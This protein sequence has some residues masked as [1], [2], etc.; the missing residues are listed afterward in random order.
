MFSR[1]VCAGTLALSLVCVAACSTSTPTAD[2]PAVGDGDA[3]SEEGPVSGAASADA[4]AE[5]GAVGDLQQ[6]MDPPP[7]V[8]ARPASPVF[9]DAEY[10]VRVTEGVR[11]GQALSHAGWQQGDAEPMDLTLDVYEPAG[12]EAEAKPAVVMIHGGGFTGGSSAHGPL[13]L[14]ARYFAERGWV[15]FSINYRLA[16]DYGT[17]PASYPSPQTLGVTGQQADQWYALYPACRDGK[18]AIRWIRAH[19]DTYGLHPEY[20]TAVGGS[21]G[22][23]IALALGVSNEEDCRDEISLA[24]DPTLADTH[25]EQSSTVATVIDHWGG[26]AILTMLQTL[27]GQ[28]R[29]DA[30]DAPVSIVHGTQDPTVSFDEALKIRAAYEDSGVPFAW[31]PLEGEGHGV[32]GATVDGSPLV[33]L[34]RDFIVEQQ[35]LEQA[36]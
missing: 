17:V 13:S 29:F 14:M 3:Q 7:S 5:D 35:G 18:A 2:E 26:T 15:A 32:W 25:L 23:F 10:D 8:D 22:S 28:T 9:V 36:R 24:D 20:L 21:A 31:H 27:G 34:A 4:G 6:E 11:Y 12:S 16:G 19:A 1:F 33:D 30:S